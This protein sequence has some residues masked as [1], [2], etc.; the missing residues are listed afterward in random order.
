MAQYFN[1]YS[2]IPHRHWF[3]F[4]SEIYCAVGQGWYC[5]CLFPS[6]ADGWMTKW[7][8]I[9]EGGMKNRVASLSF[10]LCVYVCVCVRTVTRNNVHIFSRVKYGHCI[11]Y[12][13]LLLLFLCVCVCVCVFR[14]CIAYTACC[15]L[16]FLASSWI[17]MR[18]YSLVYASGVDSRWKRKIPHDDNRKEFFCFFF[19]NK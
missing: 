6:V 13:D 17:L 3:Y 19:F 14:C 11:P 8:C 4:Y 9:G 10:S 7:C 2:I 1:I 15:S 18:F 5:W 16:L 12:R